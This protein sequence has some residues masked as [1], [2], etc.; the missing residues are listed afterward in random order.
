MINGCHS[1]TAY[2]VETGVSLWLSCSCKF[3]PWVC[4]A[5]CLYSNTSAERHS[6]V[7]GD[8]NAGL[9]VIGC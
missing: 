6:A 5:F 7:T 1:Y 3:C 9:C 2:Q 8:E 4:V